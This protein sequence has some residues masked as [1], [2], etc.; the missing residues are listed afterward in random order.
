MKEFYVFDDTNNEISY[1]DVN[2]DILPPEVAEKLDDICAEYAVEK[3]D[4]VLA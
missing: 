4:V 3:E 2:L 1:E